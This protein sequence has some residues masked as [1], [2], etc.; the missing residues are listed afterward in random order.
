M[1]LQVQIAG[2]L[3][4]TIRSIISGYKTQ[5]RIRLTHAGPRMIR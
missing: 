1:L 4:F 2:Q 5:R 3:E